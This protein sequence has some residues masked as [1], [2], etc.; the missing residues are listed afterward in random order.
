MA[1]RVSYRGSPGFSL[2]P[3]GFLILA[4]LI[5]YVATS[6]RP[7]LFIDL[8]GLSRHSLISYPWTI[9]TNMFIHAPFPSISHILANMLTLYFFGSFLMRLVGERNFLIVYFLGGL[10][11]NIVYL[12]LAPP[13]AIAIGASG[14]VFAVGG[15]MAVLRPKLTVFIFPIPAPIPLWAAVIGG[16]LLLGIALP[17]LLSSSLSSSS[18]SFRIAWQAHFGG[19]VFGLVA[20]YLFRRR[21]RFSY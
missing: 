3:M 20:G 1:Y 13:F 5:L 16:F 14:A 21:R 6:I 4:N 10:L 19:L 17:A 11:G 7:R 2:G 9:V 8:F 12:L 18:L 15:A